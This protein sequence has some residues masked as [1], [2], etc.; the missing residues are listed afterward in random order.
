VEED[1]APAR[2]WAVT[3]QP[4]LA[5]VLF[6]L[7]PVA[8]PGL[9]T[10]GVDDRWR[11]YVDRAAFARWPVEQAGAVLVHEAHHLLR[12]HAGRARAA[13]VGHA[14]HLRWNVAADCEINDDLGDVPL[15]PDSVWPE[16]FGLARGDLAE[17]YHVALPPGAL[18]GW[19]CGSGAHGVRAPYE[20]PGD[21]MDR[22]EGD[23]IRQAVAEEVR[24]RS[25]AGETLA[26]GLE[27][28]AEEFLHPRVDWRRV[29]AAAVRLGLTNV[30]GRV[31]YTY[32]RLS[33]RSATP[34]GRRVV[35]PSLVQPVPRVAV[36]VDTSGSMSPRL[37][38]MA[39]A[40]VRGI[41]RGNGVAAITVLSCDTAVH[42]TQRVFAASDV[43][44]YGGGGTELGTG[45]AAAAALRPKPQVV[46]VL[47]DGMTPWP[48]ERPPVDR[49]VVALLG[50]ERGGEPAWAQVVEVTE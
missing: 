19:E 46:V 22:A 35:L 45:L 47:T 15:P 24:R 40:E 5:S 21:G 20:P 36:V 8:R 10:V 16:T 50:A 28:W 4:Y 18:R 31:D 42:T 34:T 48:A 17:A 27:R 38:G 7:S 3:A 12:D 1:V 29:V 6:A 33:R 23:L 25:R 26:P 39:L 37:L 49:V 11:L 14:D 32:A 2:L 13:G 9:G 44:L 43:R 30:A 41:L